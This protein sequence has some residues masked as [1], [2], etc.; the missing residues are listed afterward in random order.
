MPRLYSEPHGYDTREERAMDLD[1][2]TMITGTRTTRRERAIIEG[3]RID[4]RRDVERE[5]MI[6][7]IRRA[8]PD[9]RLVHDPCDVIAH[10]TVDGEKRTITVR[11][12]EE[13]ALLYNLANEA[14]GWV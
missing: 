6:S 14:D 3:D 1:G 2:D 9:F 11:R 10:L 7:R 5:S 8:W 13:D 4:E 12:R